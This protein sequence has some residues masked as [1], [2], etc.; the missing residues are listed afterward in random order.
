MVTVFHPDH[1]DGVVSS[2][3]YDID[4]NVLALVR[5]KSG[6]CSGGYYDIA[7]PGWTING[8]AELVK[9]SVHGAFDNLPW[10]MAALTEVA[11]GGE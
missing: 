8:T 3:G 2:L 5:W 4:G 11:R 1:G 10:P 9:M 7:K 6:G